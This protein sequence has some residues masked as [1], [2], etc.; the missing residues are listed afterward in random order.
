[1]GGLKRGGHTPD[2]SVRGVEE[3]DGVSPVRDKGGLQSEGLQQ[4]HLHLRARSGDCPNCVGP[5]RAYHVLKLVNVNRS[6]LAGL[7]DL[8]QVLLSEVLG[9]GLACLSESV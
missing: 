8:Q 3:I 1:M 4:L 2:Q 6:H 7:V 5:Y 9:L